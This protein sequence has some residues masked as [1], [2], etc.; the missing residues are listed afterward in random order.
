MNTSKLR[1][2]LIDCLSKELIS[3]GFKFSKAREAFIRKTDFGQQ[4]Y[5][6]TFLKYSGQE[7]FE[8]N[9]GYHV[10]FEDVEGFFHETSYFSE[11]DK[12][13]TS[14]IGCSI[15]NHL[16]NGKDAF[17][18]SIETDEDVATACAYYYD[19]YL[20]V[21]APFFDKY[22]TLES[23]DELMNSDPEK[24]LSLINFIFRGAKGAIIAHMLGGDRLSDLIKTYGEQY[25]KFSNGFYKGDYD[26]VV[27]NIQKVTAT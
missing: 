17:R 10:R 27:E 14:T 9:P 12:K 21:V 18:Q 11:K 4:W 20:K 22:R 25:A 8:V 7:G 24:E 1:S 15:E 23:L 5:T 6:I 19:L 26:K 2:D 3:E 16:A 13:G